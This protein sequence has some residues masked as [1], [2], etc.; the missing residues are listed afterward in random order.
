MA[1]PIDEVSQ[2]IA[3]RA[4][5]TPP[6]RARESIESSSVVAIALSWLVASIA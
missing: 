2:P 5:E 6:A 4:I 3:F 1:A